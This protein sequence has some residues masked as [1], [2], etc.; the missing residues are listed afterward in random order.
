MNALHITT[1]DGKMQHIH[2]ISTSTLLN[3]NC[4]ERA[5]NVLSICHYCYSEALTKCRKQL[6]ARL[7]GNTE[8]LTKSVIPFEELPTITD[9]IFR[10]ESFGDLMNS[11]QVKNYFN[12]CRKNPFTTFA[13]WTKNPAFIDMAIKAGSA[14][15]ENII[16]IYSSPII[17]APAVNAKVLQRFPFI[18]KCFTVFTPEQAENVIINCG[19]RSCFTCRKCYSK[20]DKTFYINEQLKGVSKKALAF[21]DDALRKF[22]SLVKCLVA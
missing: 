16:I 21:L 1:H 20:D 8:L 11:T 6:E 19:S 22:K 2:S 13:L 18:D 15:P 17:G 9:D 4:R 7:K 10:F 12:I 14:K 3:E 5:K